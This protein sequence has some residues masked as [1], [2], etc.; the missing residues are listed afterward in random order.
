MLSF[1]SLSVQA[2][3]K[4]GRCVYLTSHGSGKSLRIVDKQVN[5][6]GGRGKKGKLDIIL[7]LSHLCVLCYINSLIHCSCEKK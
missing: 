6:L 7:P 4:T 5:G 3:F 1:S 2:C